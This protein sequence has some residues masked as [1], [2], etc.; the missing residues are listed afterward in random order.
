MKRAQAATEYLIILVVVVII[1]LIAVGVMRGLAE[2]GG[3]SV[4]TAK[5]KIEW[6]SQ[7]VVLIKPSLY[8]DGTGYLLIINNAN[9]PIKVTKVGVGVDPVDQPNPQRIENAARATLE[10]AKGSVAKG[11]SGKPYSFEVTIKYAHADEP[12]IVNTVKGKISG[13]YE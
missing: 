9:Y 5:S 6:Q 10:L 13:I 1:A 7:D 11:E 4:E 2:S 3:G 8:A 12:L